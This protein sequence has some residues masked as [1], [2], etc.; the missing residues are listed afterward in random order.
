MKNFDLFGDTAS[1]PHVEGQ[2]TA[3]IV[4]TIN[5][6]RLVDELTKLGIQDENFKAAVFEIDKIRQFVGSPENILGNQYTKHGEIAEQVEVGIRRAKD[7]LHGKPMGATFD[8]VGRTA[9]EDYLIDGVAV[10]SKFINGATNNL[11]HVIQHLEKYEYFG[12]DGSFYHIPKDTHALI[13]NIMKNGEAGELSQRSISKLRQLVIEIEQKTGKQF[14]DVVRPSVSNY[15]EVQQGVVHRTIDGHETNISKENTRIKNEIR[16]KHKPNQSEAAKVSLIAA[17]VGASISITTTIYQKH[18]EGKNVFKGDFTIEDW[19]EIGVEGLK[20]GATGWVSGYAIYA[21]TNYASLSAPLAASIVSALRSSG[22]L[23]KR[24][25]EGE[26][27]FDEFFE[28]SMISTSEAAIVGI[29]TFIGQSVIPIPMLGSV[30]GAVA[31]SFLTKFINQYDTET[32]LAIKERLNEYLNKLDEAHKRIVES[33]EKEYGTLNK[34][35][36]YA[37]DVKNNSRLLVASS[38]LAQQ[39]GVEKHKILYTIDDVDVFMLE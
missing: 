32:A 12:K 28:L 11:K 36:D 22:V 16:E 33:I 25:K 9:P 13:E 17:A 1:N 23:F 8:G 15:S 26:I 39:Y 38:I 21:L 27:Q 6:G 10:Q 18:K 2:I 29:C 7:V 20:G 30:I 24:Y 14:S 5:H 3:G 31:G 34:L 37:F 4:N 35:T 19:Q